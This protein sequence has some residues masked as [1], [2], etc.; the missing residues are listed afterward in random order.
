MNEVSISSPDDMLKKLALLPNANSVLMTRCSIVDIPKL[1]LYLPHLISLDLSSNPI[2]SLEPLWESNLP[3]LRELNIAACWLKSLPIGPPSF[4]LTLEVLNLDG[5]FFGQAPFG[6]Q[7]NFSVF[8]KLKTLSLVG[9]DYDTIPCLPERLEKLIFRL[10]QFSEIPQGSVIDFDASYSYIPHQPSILS[11]QI[12]ILNLS[13]C[14]LSGTLIIPQMPFLDTLDVSNN[15]ISDIQF[16]STRRIT[17]LRLSFNAIGSFP[18][19]ISKLP[20]LR[21]LEL[22]HNAIDRIPTD[23]TSFKRLESIDLSH[24]QLIAGRLKLPS[25]IQAVRF[26]FNFSVS[27]ESFPLSLR[28]VDVSFCSVVTFPPIPPSIEWLAVYFVHRIIVSVKIRALTDDSSISTD[29]NQQPADTESDD[30]AFD[31]DLKSFDS[32]PF[33]FIEEKAILGD[34]KSLETNTLMNDKLSDYIGCSATSGRSTKYEDNFLSTKYD[35][36]QFAGVFDGHVG[37][38]AAFVSAEAFANLIGRYIGPAYNKTPYELKLAVCKTFAMVND[39]LRRRDVKDGTT[40]VIVGVDNKS[41]RICVGHLG[42]SLALMVCKDRDEWL[43]KPH[44][45]MDRHEYNRMR[46]DKKSV[47]SD[48]RVDGKL[49]VSRSLGDFW[50]CDGMYD[51]P[52]VKIQEAPEGIMSIVLGCDGLWDYVAA[53]NVCN[54]VRSIRDPVKASRLLQ[55]YAY[56]SGS[57]DNISVIVLNF[58]DNYKPECP[59]KNDEDSEEIITSRW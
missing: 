15:S 22:A 36:I 18:E 46:A 27:F 42:D 57:H 30:G 7:S 20:M 51:E 24:N 34:T 35:D 54:V 49:C 2:K 16:E 59:C 40:A 50:C 38:E 10:N 29:P 21:Q 3:N 39:E 6:L 19:S 11:T 1:L 53:G 4:Y 32:D 31:E 28:Y 43:T 26:A 48:W 55:D 47:S 23:L 33:M 14:G 45:P 5:N 56:A 12:Q 52:D 8:P 17:V 13:H 44:R 41:G 25:K 37:H 9:N 58:P